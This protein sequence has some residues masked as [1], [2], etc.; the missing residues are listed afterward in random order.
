[1]QL[2]RLNEALLVSF[3]AMSGPNL[4]AVGRAREFDRDQGLDSGADGTET[5]RKGLESL[6]SGAEATAALAG[7]RSEG[8][9]DSLLA[10]Q[11]R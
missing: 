1:M 2:S 3:G 11:E 9:P 6:A 8:T 5:R 4:A 10:L 7:P